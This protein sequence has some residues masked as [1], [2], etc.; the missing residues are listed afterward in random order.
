MLCTV[1]F[2]LASKYE[3]V[4]ESLQCKSNM[5]EETTVANGLHGYLQSKEIKQTN[6]KNRNGLIIRQSLIITWNLLKARI[7]SAVQP[8]TMKYFYSMDN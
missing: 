8:V 3:T 4:S 5:T 1:G 7:S 6:K 2:P